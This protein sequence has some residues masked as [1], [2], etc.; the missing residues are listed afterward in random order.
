LFRLTDLRP[1]DTITVATGS[2]RRVRYAVTGRRVYPKTA[3]LPRAVF[4]LD[5]RPRLA[6]I[7]CGGAFDRATRSYRDN[8]V[9]FASRSEPPPG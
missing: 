5:T 6:I 4:S 9:V 2:G 3:G 8:I 7:T 1:G